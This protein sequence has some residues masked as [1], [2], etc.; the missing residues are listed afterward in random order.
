MFFYE[1]IKK[2][3]YKYYY[4]EEGRLVMNKVKYTLYIMAYFSLLVGVVVFLTD[5]IQKSDDEFVFY[6]RI[7]SDKSCIEKK[8]AHLVGLQKINGKKY[9]F[10]E[11]GIL[12]KGWINVSEQERYYANEEGE[13][14]TGEQIISDIKYKFDDDGKLVSEDLNGVKMVALTFD[15]GPSAYT[16]RILD[17]LKKYDAKATFFLI[18]QRIADYPEQVKREY[19]LGCQIGGHTYSHKYLTSMSREQLINE[20]N[21]TDEALNKITKENTSCIRP[22][23]GVYDKR[24]IEIVDCPVAMW[25]VDTLDWK[26]QDAGEVIEI[27]TTDIKN[28]DI[29]LMH[30]LYES[31]ADA[32]EEIVPKLLD[33]GFKLVTFSELI[34]ANGGAF[35][36]RVY[37]SADKIRRYNK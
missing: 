6:E 20:I 7:V 17:I 32:V 8:G 26:N 15:D 37:Y 33:Q 16:D 19:E 29:I 23:G 9:Y 28:G 35:S 1:Y 34:N 12:K 21:A 27:A 13:I 36:R 31:T 14:V 25:S 2:D 4:K 10:D 30:D 5:T 3:L 22:P 11:K 18:G 24:I